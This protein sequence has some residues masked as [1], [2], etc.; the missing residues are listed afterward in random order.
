MRNDLEGELLAINEELKSILY[1]IQ[2]HVS[3]LMVNQ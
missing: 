2:A 3:N 1:E